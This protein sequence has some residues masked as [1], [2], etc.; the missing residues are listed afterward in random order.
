MLRGWIKRGWQD[1]RAAVAPTVALALFGLIAAGGLAFD[2]A[3]MAALDTELQNAADQAALAAA[4][5]LDGVVA[6]T[7]TAELG[8]TVR[9]TN[10]ASQLVQNLAV[11]A[12]DGKAFG[13]TLHAT[14]GVRFCSAF[15][16]TI[17]D[18]QTACTSTN[19]DADAKI[20][21]VKVASRKAV[22]ALTP[23]VALLDSGDMSAE[24]VAGIG[25]AICKVPPVMICNP[26]EAGGN[27]N[28]NVGALI[29]KGL[30]LVS[31][32]GGGWAPGNYGYLNTNGGSSG[33]PGI[34]E[35]LGWETPPGQCL[36]ET[37]VDTKPGVTVTVTDALNTRFDIYD[38]GAGAGCPTGGA[39]PPSVNSTKD[40]VR[41]PGNNAASCTLG[42]NGWKEAGSTSAD[43]YLPTTNQTLVAQGMSP[44][45]A[46]G[47]PRDICHAIDSGAAGACGTAVGSGIWDR[48]AYF[49]VNYGWMTASAWQTNTNTADDPLP[50]NPTR[51][52]VYNWEILH[53]GETVGGRTILGQ[54]TIAA[55]GAGNGNGNGK[56]NSGGGGGGST[57]SAHGSPVCGPI[58][59]YGTGTVPGGSTVDRRRISVAV[60]NCLANSVNGSSTNVPVE[61]WIDVFLTEPSINRL[62]TQAGDIYVEVI[63][64]ATAG[65]SG[66]TAGQVIRRDMP[67]LI[68]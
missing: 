50:S 41:D 42:T 5:Q 12:N 2:Y 46:M 64:E 44:P 53:R 51:Y 8:A 31:N 60:V 33:A 10:A 61:T 47:Y 7:A 37:G 68:R 26:Q 1:E 54:R 21:W 40:L 29:G 36:P 24:A 34:R 63:E 49:A 27:T 52:E 16:D 55:A 15:N 32:G 13:V 65:A 11:F 18:T 38:N 23:V 20:V 9:A 56:G 35:A 45:R 19:L 6:S 67:Y 39:C 3:R 48:D 59:G 30:K 22:Y 57:L 4:S 14:E 25:A 17:A 43:V 58:A 62:R 28:F 66:A